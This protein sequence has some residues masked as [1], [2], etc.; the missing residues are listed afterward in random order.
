MYV[1]ESKENFFKMLLRYLVGGTIGCY[2]AAPVNEVSS[3]QGP[4][5]EGR[6]T[7]GDALKIFRPTDEKL[8]FPAI[9]FLM[10]Y[11]GTFRVVTQTQDVDLYNLT[12][13]HHCMDGGAAHAVAREIEAAGFDPRAEDAL[14]PNAPLLRVAEAG[15]AIA[16]AARSGQAEGNVASA[17]LILCSICEMGGLIY[18]LF[19]VVVAT[20]LLALLPLCN[21][22]FQVCFDAGVAVSTAARTAAVLRKAKEKGNL[23]A[24]QARL[25]AGA[26]DAAGNSGLGSASN[27]YTSNYSAAYDAFRI[28][29]AA[30]DDELRDTQ[31]LTAQQ[32]RALRRRAIIKAERGRSGADWPRARATGAITG[33]FEGAE[34]MLRRWA[35]L[36]VPRPGDRADDKEGATTGSSSDEYESVAADDR[37]NPPPPPLEHAPAYADLLSRFGA[38]PT[39]PLRP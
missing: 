26:A 8:C 22:C 10:P 3:T 32:K 16:N 37:S 7:D 17:G 11:L 34:R 29:E 35:W 14:F 36:G 28:D 13:A 9:P 19:L 39:T 18:T 27:P 12:Y 15:D 30:L 6:G 31:M 21:F 2:A 23:P 33:A 5:S 24:M 4:G 20:I 25:A 1:P 38:T